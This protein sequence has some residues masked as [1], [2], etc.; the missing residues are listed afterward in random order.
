MGFDK[1]GVQARAGS[2]KTERTRTSATPATTYRLEQVDAPQLDAKQEAIVLEVDVV[3]D[4]DPVG[5]GW[6]VGV[7]RRRGEAN[8]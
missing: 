4:E 2:G 1:L 3:Y 7:E 8:P 5:S 6:C